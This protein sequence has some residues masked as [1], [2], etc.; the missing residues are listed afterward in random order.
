MKIYISVDIE[1]IAG[2]VHGD[3][4]STSGGGEFM[5]ARRWM[6]QEVNA[7]AEGFFAAGAELVVANDAHGGQRNIL[8]EELLPDIELITGSPKP[9]TQSQG[10]I[11]PDGGSEFDAVAFVGY[12]AKN[13]SMGILSHTIS[14][15][16]VNEVKVNGRPLGEGGLNAAIAAEL[17]LPVIFMAGDYHAC[18][19]AH[20]DYHPLVTVATKTA[21]TRYSA[22]SLT[23]QK[24]QRLIREGAQKAYTEY[25]ADKS[26]GFIFLQE[27]PCVIELR[28]HNSGT[29]DNSARMP[30]T[31][32]LNDITLQFTAPNFLEG[33]LGLRAMIAMGS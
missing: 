5:R 6:T 19:E 13:G 27:R 29:C 12:H 14:G 32:R 30:G 23:P 11:A 15:G 21:I 22:R 31:K 28:F 3:H 8:I 24:A 18:Q 26:K 4:C 25:A 9:F 10:L 33:F 20:E 17:G 2:V 16:V 1:G 7:A